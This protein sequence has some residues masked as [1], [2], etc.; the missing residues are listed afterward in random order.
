MDR[1]I[2]QDGAA[3]QLTPPKDLGEITIA[4]FTPEFTREQYE[5][6]ARK[7]AQSAWDAWSS[8]HDRIRN[9]IENHT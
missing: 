8:E 7:W 3:E 4:D 6:F 5:A 9:W 2:K 1:I